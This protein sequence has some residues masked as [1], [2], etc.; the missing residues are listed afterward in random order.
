MVEMIDT[1]IKKPECKNGFIL[2]GF[3]RTVTQAEKVRL[4]KYGN[5]V[6]MGGLVT[7]TIMKLKILKK[8][9]V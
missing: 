8:P 4:A 5:G 7:S 3:P 6:V 1:S 2:D 9:G